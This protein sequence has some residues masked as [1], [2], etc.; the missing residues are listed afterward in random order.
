[1]YTYLHKVLIPKGLKPMLEGFSRAVVRCKPD[2][3]Q[4]FAEK[5]FKALLTFRVGSC[6]YDIS[7]S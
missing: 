3:V 2:S 5:Y 4:H 7:N 6:Y 1:M